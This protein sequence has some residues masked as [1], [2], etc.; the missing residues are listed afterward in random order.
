M[1]HVIVYMCICLLWL[2]EDA[3]NIETLLNSLGA[4]ATDSLRDSIVLH[5]YAGKAAYF[6]MSA[7]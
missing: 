5:V 1:C 4:S 7:K 6:D 2:I 3:E